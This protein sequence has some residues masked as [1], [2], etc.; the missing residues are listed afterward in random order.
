MAVCKVRCGLADEDT[1]NFVELHYILQKIV[2]FFGILFLANS[3]RNVGDVV[4]HVL[5]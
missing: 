2:V 4:V 3:R 5:E 1:S